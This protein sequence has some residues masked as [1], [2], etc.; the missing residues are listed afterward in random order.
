MPP[1]CQVSNLNPAGVKR[2]QNELGSDISDDDVFH[3]VYGVLHSNDFRSE[4]EASLKKEAPRVPMAPDRETFDAF[5]NAGKELLDLH[6]N[7][8]TVDP[9]PLTEEWADDVDPETNPEL[10]LVTTK[11]MSYRDKDTKDALIYNPHLTL[12]G[13]PAQTQRYMLGTR[14]AIDWLIDRY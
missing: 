1:R 7:Y 10:L 2:F 6:A 8:E 13:I 14:S 9:Y 11:K 4:F 3:Y 5:A 12:S